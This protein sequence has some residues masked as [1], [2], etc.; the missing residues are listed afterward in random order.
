M[1]LEAMELAE[2]T[3]LEMEEERALTDEAD[4]AELWLASLADAD[5]AEMA[6]PEAEA[7]LR[8]ELATDATELLATAPVEGRRKVNH[9]SP[10]FSRARLTGSGTDLLAQLS[11]LGEIGGL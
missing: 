2:A 11:S 8:A 5:E 9:P 1:R 10:S 4:S 6:L 7:L 3:L